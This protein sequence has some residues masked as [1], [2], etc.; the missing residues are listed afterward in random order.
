MLWAPATPARAAASRVDPNNV[1]VADFEGWGTALAWGGNAVGGWSDADSDEPTTTRRD[2]IAD[3][4][5]SPAKGLGLNVVRYHIGAG[6]ADNWEALGCGKQRPG[7]PVPTYLPK[8]GAWDWTAD[9][10]QRWFAQAAQG[11]GAN[12]WLAYASS[13]PYWMT[14]NGCS[15]GAA[16]GGQNLK[17]YWGYHGDGT[18]AYNGTTSYSDTTDDSVTVAFDGTQISFFGGRSSDSGRAAISVDGGS[19]TIV[20]LYSATR[21]G[22]QLLYTSPVLPSGTHTLKVRVAGSKNA[23]STGYFISPDR[24]VIGGTSVDD[25][26]RGTGL[27]QFNYHWH[28][29]EPYAAYLT[30]VTKHFRDTWGI[31]FDL[32]DP[33]NEPEVV[34]WAQTGMQE[35]ASFDRSSQDEIVNRFG[36]SL[37]AEGLTETRVA[38]PDGYSVANTNS[39][40]LS[41]SD[42]A[43]NYVSTLTTHTYGGTPDEKRALRDT[44]SSYNKKLWMSEVGS[45]GAGPDP[46]AV[47]PAI[48]LAS[49]IV[50]DMMYLR[51]TAWIQWDGIESWEMNV[52]QNTSWGLIW[53]NYEDPNHTYTVAKQYYGYGNF[54]KFI[55]PGYQI[56]DS[57]DP[58]TLAAYDPVGRSVVLVAYNDTNRAR[59]IRYDLGKFTK[60]TTATP[61]RTS[62]TKN[63]E[64]LPG[65]AVNSNQLSV[66][67]DPKS[68][69]TYVMSS[70]TVLG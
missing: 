11:R 33:L 39:A 60:I 62:G 48:N 9:A 6:Q 43:K 16:D 15:N 24:V 44:A 29:Y 57:G 58:Q 28:M 51:P 30:E 38:A 1:H 7:S 40:F 68:I 66:T 45:G 4:L 53:G 31:T 67:L 20:D 22:N 36:Q 46:T 69:T 25:Q 42:S 18:G 23:S 26:V 52:R 14:I 3:L 19:E 54:S 32:V 17:G 65:V 55:R 37:A 12:K 5:F 49:Q 8:E 34:G 59:S 61:Y 35:G 41:Y 70:A 2:R 10:N 21:Q 13:P 47:Q 56:I 64:Q 50:S 27:N 63:L